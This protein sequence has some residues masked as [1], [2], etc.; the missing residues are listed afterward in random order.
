MEVTG[1]GLGSRGLPLLGRGGAPSGLSPLLRP[2]RSA[3]VVR[4]PP[5][6]GA[7][8]PPRPP[9]T[10]IP[11]P[12]TSLSPLCA[13]PV[14][15]AHRARLRFPESPNPRNAARTRLPSL[16]L[17]GERLGG[18]LSGDPRARSGEPGA[19]CCPAAGRR[20]GL[21]TRAPSSSFSLAPQI[22]P[23]HRAFQSRVNLTRSTLLKNRFSF[24]IGF[25][26]RKSSK[27]MK[28]FPAW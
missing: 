27:V 26:K 6:P 3:A 11:G 13:Q 24:G 9:A 22:N 4:S 8:L 21:P 5:L 7:A 2:T 10:H 12:P 16:T 20:P 14:P 18:A 23:R 1:G 19:P 25:L 15:P 17:G 28:T